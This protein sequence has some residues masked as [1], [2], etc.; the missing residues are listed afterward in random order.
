MRFV[1]ADHDCEVA[2]KLNENPHPGPDAPVLNYDKI[3]HMKP[4]YVKSS[5]WTNH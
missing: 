4:R 1:D 3:Q 5:E 2:K